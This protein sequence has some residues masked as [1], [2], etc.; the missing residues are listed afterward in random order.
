[1]AYVVD[2]AGG[3]AEEDEVARL[4]RRAIDGLADGVLVGETRGSGTPDCP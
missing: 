3:V 2:V 4:Q 1:M